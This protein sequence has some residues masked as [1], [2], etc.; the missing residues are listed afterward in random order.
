MIRVD[1]KTGSQA[2]D[3]TQIPTNDETMEL[4]EKMN[5][6]NRRIANT[7]QLY[8][9]MLSY[10]KNLVAHSSGFSTIVVVA[11]Q[12]V[13]LGM[14]VSGVIAMFILRKGITSRKSR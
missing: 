1:I 14:V 4:E 3:I 6:L 8:N 9:G 7:V 5:S 12:L 2:G 11:S 10:E 13:A